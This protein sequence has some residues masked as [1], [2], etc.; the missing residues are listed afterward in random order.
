MVYEYLKNKFN[1]N[2]CMNL[3]DKICQRK[4]VRG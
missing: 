2:D 4:D 3:S 1:A